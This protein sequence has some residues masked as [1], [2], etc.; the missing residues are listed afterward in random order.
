MSITVTLPDGN[1]L[2]LPDGA[3]GADAAAAIGPGL[4]RAALAV[5][6]SHP[7][8]GEEPQLRDLARALPDGA[9][10]AILTQKSGPQALQLIRHDAAHVLAAA[11]MD[12]YDGV[13]IS[14]GPPIE[15]GFYYD[16]E[17]PEGTTVSE[18]DFPE[19]EQ[20]MRAHVKASEAFVREDVPVA[21]ARERFLGERQDYKVELIDDLVSAAAA[22]DLEGGGATTL[23][24]VSLYTNGPFTDLCRGPHAP[25]TGTVGAVKLQSVAGA[26]WRGDSNRTMLTRIYGTAFFTKAGLEE[27]LERIEQAKARDHRKLGRE[28]GLFTFSELS[29]GSPFWKPA[30]MAIWNALTELWRTENLT[31]GY[32][33]VKTP[34]LYDVELWKQ[35]GHW[36]KYKDNMYF[37]DVEG[38]PMGLKPMNCPAHI[39]IYNDE[40]RSYRDLPVR[41]SEAGLVHRH[42]PSGVLHGLLRVR[43]ITQDDAHIFCTDEQVEHEVVQCL[44]F[45]FDLYRLFGFQPRLELSTRPD[46][47]IGSD[48]M[49]DRAE[50]ALAGALDSEGLQY[51][52][53]PGDGAFYGPKIDMHMTDSIGR[54]WQLGTV[55]LDYSMPERFDLLYTGA[56]NSEHRPVMIHRALLG[57]F[58]RFIGILIEHYA[59]ELPLWLAP[60]QAIVLSVS[61]RFN[62]YGASVRDDLAAAGIRVELDERS[63][64]IGRKIREAELRKIP[65]M[66][67]VGEREQRDGA[68]SVRAHRD[69]D[70]G[71]E[72]AAQFAQRVQG[73]LYSSTLRPDK[74]SHSHA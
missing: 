65:Y 47:R 42:E 38:R 58:E 18:A 41:Y 26:Y 67:V 61:D 23:E 17:F 1:A 50:A 31:R 54:S 21:Q 59:G 33:E 53:N 39:Q 34:I 2:E 24:T 14:I 57:S 36:D 60:V 15:D 55:Q 69:G 11:V 49:W 74:S 68:V 16:F 70:Q 20:R 29:P 7:D 44:R 28:L 73:E 8:N 62:D 10:I 63:E 22:G 56:D 43:H 6:L 12:L 35:S 4:A 66:L 32:R 40:R 51:E 72:P 64:S 27:H 13:K 45:G 25:S 48:E 71:S 5:E 30:G 37:T 52:L 3:T 46:K 19:I 9:H